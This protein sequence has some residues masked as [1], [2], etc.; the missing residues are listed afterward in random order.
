[1]N[2]WEEN[3]NLKDRQESTDLAQARHNVLG[4]ANIK[5]VDPL[6]IEL[7]KLEVNGTRL[8]MSGGKLNPQVDLWLSKLLNPDSIVLNSFD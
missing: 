7:N 3:A 4:I 8:T 5:E 2:E 1:M 6:N